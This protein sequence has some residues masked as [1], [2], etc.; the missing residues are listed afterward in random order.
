MSSCSRGNL[1]CCRATARRNTAR[2][3]GGHAGGPL[4]FEHLPFSTGAI[5]GRN[6]GLMELRRGGSYARHPTSYG[7]ASKSVRGSSAASSSPR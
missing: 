3:G 7:W 6:S 1:R 4:G 5:P 2:E